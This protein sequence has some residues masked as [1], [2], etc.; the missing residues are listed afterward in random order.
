MITPFIP[1]SHDIH[2][3]NE[4]LNYN[5]SNKIQFYTE[6]ADFSNINSFENDIYLTR[7]PLYGLQKI[8]EEALIFS[9]ISMSVFNNA[10]KV[11]YELSGNVIENIDTNNLTFSEYGTAII[12]FDGPD[13]SIFSLE[14][15]K[16]SIGYFSEI[17]N[18]TFKFNN[19]LMTVSKDELINVVVTLNNDLSDYLY[20]IQECA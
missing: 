19:R 12:D 10:M 18:K 15:G 17:N 20:K 2:Q 6:D 1:V 13:N 16:D 7:V 5:S 8:F 4:F 9:K 11:I 14:I 3:Y